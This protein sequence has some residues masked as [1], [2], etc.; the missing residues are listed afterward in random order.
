MTIEWVVASDVSK[1]RDGIGLE[2]WL[3]GELALCI[4]RD[5]T[6]LTR[7][8]TTYLPDLP[9]SLLDEAMQRFQTELWDFVP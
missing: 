7:T 1:G 9:L 8:L 2:L 5:D 6:L 3:D 4:F